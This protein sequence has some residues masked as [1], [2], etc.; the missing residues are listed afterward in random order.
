MRHVW[1]ERHVRVQDRQ[2]D[3]SAVRALRERTREVLAG[4]APAVDLGCGTGTGALGLSAPM[5]GVD[6]SAT[7]CIEA[8]R[9]GLPTCM[10]D[11]RA[12]PIRGRSV[13]AVRCD[14]VLYHLE[15][16]E[17]A[18]AEAARVLRPGGRIACAHPDHES[19]VLEVPGAPA[20][21]L[22]LTKRGR[23]DLNYQCG[24]VPRRVP[25]ILLGLGFVD[26]RTEAFTVVAEHPDAEPFAIP[27]WLREWRDQGLLDVSD[28]E[29]KEWDT[30]VDRARAR[31][32]FLFTLTYLLTYG[33]AT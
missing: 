13:S 27:L 25:A 30:A 18:L 3:L 28:D 5:F 31:G 26:V 12:L 9:R 24:T 10:A 21:L 22:A 4:L 1:D 20:H 14:R 29:L 32:G 8:A 11:V 16:P 17:L 2:N 15:T 6:A 23:T 19:I 33:T 7:M